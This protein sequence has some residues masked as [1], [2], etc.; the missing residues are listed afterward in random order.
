MLA[1]LLISTL[2][3]AVQTLAETGPKSRLTLMPYKAVV[4]V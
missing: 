4:G 2:H 3:V 1:G